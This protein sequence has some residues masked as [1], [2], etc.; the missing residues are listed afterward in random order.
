[1]Y[2][3]SSPRGSGQ[4]QEQKKAA[5]QQDAAMIPAGAQDESLVDISLLSN[6]NS[7]WHEWIKGAAREEMKSSIL[8]AECKAE[9]KAT[10]QVQRMKIEY[11]AKYH[12]GLEKAHV[13]YEQRAEALKAECRQYGQHLQAGTRKRLEDAAAYMSERLQTQAAAQEMQQASAAGRAMIFEEYAQRCQ[14][15]LYVVTQ[16]ADERHAR[17]LQEVANEFNAQAM[18]WPDRIL[19]SAGTLALLGGLLLT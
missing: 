9:E 12:E 1:M 10:Q 3:I 4:P 6:I 19:C 16:E 2:D 17:Q 18:K 8:A 11:S 7:V 14:Q 5:V 15:E 13:A